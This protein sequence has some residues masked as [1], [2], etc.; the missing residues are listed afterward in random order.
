MGTKAKIN[1]L[2]LILLIVLL[3]LSSSII[4]TNSSIAYAAY[5]GELSYDYE[6][7]TIENVDVIVSNETVRPG[8]IVELS[9][10]LTP[11]YAEKTVNSIEYYISNNNTLVNSTNNATISQNI[12]TVS[13]SAEI[14]EIIDVVAVA[15]GKQSAIRS[16]HIVKIPVDNVTFTTTQTIINQGA[17]YT[18][19]ISI[20]PENASNREVTYNIIKGSEYFTYLGNNQIKIND[21]IG[22]GDA[23]LELAATVDGVQS[24]NRILI[25]IFVPIDA[26]SLSVSSTNPLCGDTVNFTVGLGYATVQDYSYTIVSGEEFIESFSNDI[27]KIKTNISAQSP[28]ISLYAVCNGKRSNTISINIQIPVTDLTASITTFNV[29]E[30]AKITLPKPTINPTNATNKQYTYRIISGSEHINGTITNGTFSIKESVSVPDGKIVIQAIS[31]SSSSKSVSFT[32]NIN[33]P[34]KT[35]TIAANSTQLKST[36]TS[37]TSVTFTPTFNE[38]TTAPTNKAITYYVSEGLSNVD[39][40][41]ISSGNIL[42]SNQLKVKNGATKG[43]IKVYAIAGSKNSNTISLSIY[44]PVQSITLNTTYQ[45]GITIKPTVNSNASNPAVTITGFTV[46]RYGKNPEEYSSVSGTEFAVKNNSAKDVLFIPQSLVSGSKIAITYKASE[47]DGISKTCTIT[48]AP[49]SVNDF[50]LVYS[51]DY[52]LVNSAKSFR[53]AITSNQL[54]TGYSVD[55]TV[56][57]KGGNLLSGLT[58]KIT[59]VTQTLATSNGLSLTVK[60]NADGN[61]TINY[62]VTVYDGNKTYSIPQKSIKVF[63]RATVTPVLNTKTIVSK[64]TNLS[65]GAGSLTSIARPTGYTAVSDLKF[66]A[67]NDSRYSLSEDGAFVV[68]SASIPKTVKI[69]IILK[70]NYNGINMEKLWELS[71]NIM[72]M[73]IDKQSGE[74]GTSGEIITVNNVTGKIISPT[75]YGY[76]FGGYYTGINGQGIQLFNPDGSRTSQPFSTSYSKLYAKWIP[77]EY[78]IEAY[79]T[80]NGD[81]GN[82]KFYTQKYGEPFRYQANA[83]DNWIFQGWCIADLNGER[84]YTADWTC[85]LTTPKI[86]R[87]G[88]TVRLYTVWTQDACVATGSQITLA[89]GTQKAV[90]N[91]NGDESLLVWDLWT[92]KFSTAPILFMDSDSERVNK[93]INLSFSDGTTVKIITEHGFW[94][95]DL[96]KYVYLHEDASKYIG[97]YFAKQTKVGEASVLQKV[98]LTDVEITEE[99]TAAWSPVTFG[100]LCYFVNGMLSM[101]GA[102]E[103]FVNIFDVDITTMQ[104]DEVQ[105]KLDILK[106]GLFTYEEFAE[107]LPIPEVIFEAF[108][109]QYLKV[110]IG[111]G[112]TTMDELAMLIQ[113]YEKFFE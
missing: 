92:G 43:S 98:Q 55:L 26:V 35:L 20:I 21:F 66:K 47:T 69:Q 50:T 54:E 23:E 106:Y 18:L 59:S 102:T 73:N 113:R 80:W 88:Y 5:E 99:K 19:P 24:N 95:Y 16:L 97:H 9:Y 62:V 48:V 74:G 104:Y 56:K 60:D 8:S 101:P 79:S 33:V 27:L 44:I 41:S 90:E 82:S 46:T 109:G 12:L 22:R 76:D 67:L 37:G 40:V 14:G 107:I 78:K 4:A 13:D 53:Y 25:S 10:S 42:K 87:K 7:V 36:N 39:P 70:Q 112:L 77:W 64:N 86:E 32:Y 72:K 52:K 17:E 31:L 111:K 110:A 81:R 105:I 68:L 57:Y 11:Q 28:I 30:G 51:K 85:V 103:S 75:R 58:A 1:L 3:V 6:Y 45:R 71:L 29:T 91:L 34:V 65:I 2:L 61:S 38:G 108:G 15:D 83:V 49:L 94:D 63:R 100:H 84:G 89:D 96:N 93:V